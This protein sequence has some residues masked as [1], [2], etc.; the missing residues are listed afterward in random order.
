MRLADL[1]HAD[2]VVTELQAT[3]RDGAIRELAAA[4]VDGGAIAADQLEKVVEEAIARENQGTTGFGKGVAVPHVKL[5]GLDH[6]VATIGC[7]SQGLDFQSLDRAPVYTVLML[8]SP[9]DRPEDHIGA[10]ETIFGHLLR[11]NFRRFLRQ[12][13]SKNAILE[14]IQDADDL[15]DE[16]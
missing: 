3:D 16:A 12:A 7:S 2:S 1:I 10:M 14:V 6:Q 8:I 4:M 13:D 5:D 15:G 9:K 11:D